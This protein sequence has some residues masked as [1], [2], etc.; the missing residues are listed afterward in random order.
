[1]VLTSLQF[2][3]NFSDLD[4]GASI[5]MYA[6]GELTIPT[7]YSGF[8][9]SGISWGGVDPYNKETTLKFAQAGGMTTDSVISSNKPFTFNGITYLN[10][11]INEQ[12]PWHIQ[13]YLGT[14]LKYD[15]VAPIMVGGYAYEFSDIDRLVFAFP[16]IGEDRLG[17]VRFTRLMFNEPNYS[18]PVSLPGAVILLGAGL[19]RLVLYSRRKLI[20]K[21]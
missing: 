17:F 5:N 11:Y 1:M 12:Q 3:I 7:G 9:W 14:V 18:P 6:L 19:G 8:N 13:G 16:Q 4:G 10:I 20:G 15:M 21:N 2:I